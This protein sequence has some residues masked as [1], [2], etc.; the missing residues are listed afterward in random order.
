MQ[1]KQGFDVRSQQSSL[2]RSLVQNV[3]RS[4][5]KSTDLLNPYH[6]YV[7]SLSCLKGRGYGDISILKFLS[8]NHYVYS[9]RKSVKM[10]NPG[11]LVGYICILG[12]YQ[13]LFFPTPTNIL[14]FFY[15][16]MNN[17]NK[18][19][20]CYSYTSEQIAYTVTSKIV[21]VT[22]NSKEENTLRLLYQFHPRI[23]PLWTVLV[24]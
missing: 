1:V 14:I 4:N 2:R 3:S 6:P 12:I 16:N 9:P 8:W 7:L 10:E 22:V 11:Y 21:V 24:G 5:K 18:Q 13:N 17:M 20:N 19:A 15:F 23:R